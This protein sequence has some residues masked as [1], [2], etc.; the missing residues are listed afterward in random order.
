M[1]V[2]IKLSV[3]FTT[4]QAL[5]KTYRKSFDLEQAP[6]K[7]EEMN[8]AENPNLSFVVTDVKH[9]IGSDRQCVTIYAD[10]AQRP[11]EFVGMVL[12]RKVFKAFT[13]EAGWLLWSEKD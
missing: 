12:T 8:F 2:T 10:Y 3:P 5:K 6:S 7:G 1:Q 9:T 13:R 11:G 4:D